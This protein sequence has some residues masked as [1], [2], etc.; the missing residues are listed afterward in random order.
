M[1]GKLSETYFMYLEDMEWCYHF[2]KNQL[3]NFYFSDSKIIH[4][5]V[6]S[7][8]VAFK[9]KMLLQNH[10]HF[11][12]HNYGFCYYCIDRLLFMIDSL[13]WKLTVW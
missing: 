3:C 6:R 5:G 13:E 11:I 1:D 10:L 12:K 4:Y 8:S 9:N 2:K 7:S